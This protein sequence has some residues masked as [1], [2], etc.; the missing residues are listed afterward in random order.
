MVF[1]VHHGGEACN[2]EM[3]GLEEALNS[4]HVVQ[5]N[6]CVIE[7]SGTHLPNPFYT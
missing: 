6:K 2:P 7:K 4:Y 1:N 5:T 3:T